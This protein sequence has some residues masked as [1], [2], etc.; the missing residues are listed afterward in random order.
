MRNHRITAVKKEHTVNKTIKKSANP[1]DFYRA[2]VENG[3]LLMTPHCACGN[4]LNEDYFCEKC[5][6]RCECYQIICDTKDTLNLVQK[7]IRQSPKFASFTACL[8]ADPS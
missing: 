4:A 3:L 7:Y 1:R 5:N 8:A 2:T 6:K